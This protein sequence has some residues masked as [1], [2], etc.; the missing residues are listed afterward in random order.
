MVHR[1]HLLISCSI[2]LDPFQV[3]IFESVADSSISPSRGSL[4]HTT[5]SR[6]DHRYKIFHHIT[7]RTLK[8]YHHNIVYIFQRFDDAGRAFRKRKNVDDEALI[9]AMCLSPLRR[10]SPSGSLSSS[11][12]WGAPSS[13]SQVASSALQCSKQSRSRP[14]SR[15]RRGHIAGRSSLCKLNLAG[16]RPPSP[17][18]RGL[19]SLQK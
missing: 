14:C 3:E 5:L 9:Q 11:G 17:R 4:Y 15:R 16:Y 8:W 10:A 6:A 12:G 19:S 2:P 1:V 18:T 7:N 13:G